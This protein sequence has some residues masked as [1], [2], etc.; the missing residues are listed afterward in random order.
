MNAV[1][2]ETI[3]Q[4]APAVA[5][6]NLQNLQ[7]IEDERQKRIA[8]GKALAKKG[9]EECKSSLPLTKEERKRRGNKL[10]ETMRRV[11]DEARESGLTEE[12]LE[13]LLKDI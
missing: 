9:L 1:I 13:E 6:S 2:K 11:S 4:Q 10:L 7:A 12:I 3:N 8:A 5:E